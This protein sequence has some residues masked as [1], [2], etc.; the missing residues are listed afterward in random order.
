MIN[1]YKI[2]QSVNGGGSIWT[3]T[4]KLVL[5][6]TLL[7]FCLRDL[8]LAA[9]QL[10]PRPWFWRQ[11]LALIMSSG[12][13][14]VPVSRDLGCG[15]F[16]LYLYC[17]KWSEPVWVRSGCK[18]K[19]IR[20]RSSSHSWQLGRQIHLVKGAFLTGTRLLFRLW[21]ELGTFRLQPACH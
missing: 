8:G 19:H 4:P 15:A 3:L 18:T 11:D 5:L 1:L 10:L 14:T 13:S 17:E 16:L 9:C 6:A 12:M 21:W 2:L 20:N 7:L